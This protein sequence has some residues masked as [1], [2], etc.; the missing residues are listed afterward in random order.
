MAA[1][2]AGGR[3]ALVLGVAELRA[4]HGRWK[5]REKGRD[6]E[7]AARDVEYEDGQTGAMEM[8]AGALEQMRGD[9]S[10]PGAGEGDRAGVSMEELAKVLDYLAAD[11]IRQPRRWVF[12]CW[13]L[14][15]AGERWERR[16]G[17]GT[18]GAWTWLREAVVIYGSDGEVAQ[19]Y[20]EHRVK[21][22]CGGLRLRLE[23]LTLAGAPLAEA[24]RKLAETRAALAREGRV[25][26]ARTVALVRTEKR[27]AAR[28][29]FLLE[30]EKRAGREGVE[31]LKYDEMV[32]R[33]AAVMATYFPKKSG[34]ADGGVL[35][36][37]SGISRQA[38]GQK[39]QRIAA[40]YA[41]QTGGKAGFEG[42]G[43]VRGR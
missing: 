13:R 8:A 5:R 21:K 7:A 41:R 4:I 25:G 35:A 20:P 28:V 15:A 34:I 19:V 16:R 42:L 43:A 6:T 10:G 3:P 14:L 38:A 18:A 9:A 12:G 24:R 30:Q 40:N 32:G 22:T 2:L 29:Q 36:R 11:L 17:E 1:L 23:R 33:L 27:R 39:K 31:Q 26:N 37:A